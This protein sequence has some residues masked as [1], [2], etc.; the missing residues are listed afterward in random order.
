MQAQ[1][2]RKANHR[3]TEARRIGATGDCRS[4]KVEVRESTRASAGKLLALFAL[5][6]FVL[7]PVDTMSLAS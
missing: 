6:R 1:L 5:W 3:D 2:P 7:G 4:T